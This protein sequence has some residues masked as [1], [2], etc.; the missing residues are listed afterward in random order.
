[1]IGVLR[2]GDS[3]DQSLAVRKGKRY[4]IWSGMAKPLATAMPAIT[5]GVRK[6][7]QVPVFMGY[8]FFKALYLSHPFH[9]Y[10]VRLFVQGDMKSPLDKAR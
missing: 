4:G 6:K 1:M 7:P 9:A 3:P 2:L 5:E 10:C 8:L